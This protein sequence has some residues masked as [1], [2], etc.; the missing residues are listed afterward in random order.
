MLK[1]E[2]EE[3]LK[4]QSRSRMVTLEAKTHEG[5]LSLR[6]AQV[7]EEF[8]GEIHTRSPGIKSAMSS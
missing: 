5:V 8:R 3:L 7:A 2:R 4:E 6:M 1:A